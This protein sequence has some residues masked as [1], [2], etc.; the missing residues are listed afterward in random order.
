M[1]F[2]LKRL[3]WIVFFLLVIIIVLLTSLT[4]LYKQEV[5]KAVKGVLEEHL[6][7]DFSIDN[8]KFNYYTRP[9]ELTLILEGLKVYDESSDTLATIGQTYFTCE[10]PAML[11]GKYT[12]KKVF[13]TDIH[14][15]LKIDQKGKSNYEDILT[16]SD[17]PSSKKLNFRLTQ[18][19]LEQVFYSF[20]NRLTQTHYQC[21]SPK[22]AIQLNKLSSPIHM[23]LSAEISDFNLTHSQKLIHQEPFMKIMAKVSYDFQTSKASFDAAEFLIKKSK[24]LLNGS[25]QFKQTDDEV[26]IQFSSEHKDLSPLI[27][28]LSQ[29][30]YEKLSHF[31]TRGN[32]HFNGQISGTWSAQK[33][34]EISITFGANNIEIISGH[35]ISPVMQNVSFEGVFNNGNQRSWTSASLKINNL[36]GSLADR[37]FRANFNLHNLIHPFLTGKLEAGVDL[38][39]LNKF[40]PIDQVEEIQ[41]ILGLDLAFKGGLDSSVYHPDSSKVRG[42]IEFIDI[43]LQM[44]GSPMYFQGVNAKL[45]LTNQEIQLKSLGGKAGNTDFKMQGVI[46]NLLSY[47]TSSNAPLGFKGSLFAKT[48]RLED[49][50][51]LPVKAEGE[52]DFNLTPYFLNLPKRLDLELTCNLQKFSFRKFQAS[53]VQGEVRLQNRI[54]KTNN[55]KAN[56]ANG[57]LNLVAILN[58]RKPNFI[59]F[60]GRLKLRRTNAKEVFTQFEDFSQA[61]IKSNHIQG[62]L[63]TDIKYAMVFNRNLWIQYPHLVADIQ[64]NI[65][66]GALK[67]LEIFQ[68]MDDIFNSNL[69]AQLDFNRLESIIQVRNKTIYFPKLRIKNS[70][71]DLNLIGQAKPKESIDYTIKLVSSSLSL[72]DERAKNGKSEYYLSLK[73]TPELYKFELK[74]PKETP[75]AQWQKE[76]SDYLKLF[77]EHSLPNEKFQVDTL[78]ITHIP[79]KNKISIASAL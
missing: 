48:F 17:I 60:D 64:A 44:L 45:A 70:N 59:N 65:N 47:M 21:Q 35:N 42:N 71:T 14:L 62:V 58:A 27:A 78:Q 29:H 2:L 68:K 22:L 49:L 1:N 56:F 11:Q 66:Q 23:D 50:I 38:T 20:H 46:S 9:G 16:F 53:A 74:S 34:P 33:Q 5:A 54:L 37:K 26:N 4:V 79:N 18:I 40:Y 55:L 67:K 28:V 30:Y 13:A 63:D 73:G 36:Q 31:K 10:L 32:I 52:P 12:I 25:Y 51:S 61:F 57:N 72:S 3:M 69:F 7:A 43:Q 75:Q 41:G 39:A 15:N 19:N 77:N 8:I 76:K 24:F 6:S